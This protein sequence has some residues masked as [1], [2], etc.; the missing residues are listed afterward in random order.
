MN[1]LASIVTTVQR[2]PSVAI[3][4]GV[5]LL[6][7]LLGG[8]LAWALRD[9]GHDSPD[10]ATTPAAARAFA[11]GDLRLALPDGWERVRNGPAVPGFDRARTTFVSSLSSEVAFAL[12]PPESPTLLPAKLA[13]RQGANALRPRILRAGRVRAYH[14][15]TAVGAKPVI[16]VY[17]APTTRGTATIACSSTVYELGECRSVVAALRLARGS[18]LP[19]SAD[20]AFLERLPA[21]VAKLN[22]ERGA[23]RARLTHAASAEAGAR[24]ATRLAASYAAAGGALRPLLGPEGAARATVRV[25]DRLRAEHLSLALALGIHDRVAFARAAGTIGAHEDR[26]ARRLAAWQR[27]LPR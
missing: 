9:D 26:L 8:V 5:P 25:L 20:A 24:V 22:A 14:Y 12:L 1:A 19:L 13:S 3:L 15:V 4:V 11:A 18:F 21:V 27:S 6:A 2:R 23:L 16:D 10:R 7:A 17:A